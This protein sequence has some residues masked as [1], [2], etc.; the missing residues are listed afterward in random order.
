MRIA[1]VQGL[2]TLKNKAAV[3]ALV[4]AAG[5]EA[6]EFDAIQALAQTPDVHALSAYLTGL[7]SKNADLRTACKTAIAADPRRGG[8]GPGAAGQGQRGQAGAAARI[9]LHLL[10]SRA[11]PAMAADRPVPARRQGLPAGDGAEVRRRLHQ[12]RQAGEVGEPQGRRQAA[13]PDDARPALLAEQRRGRL[14]LRR[15]RV[16]DGPRR[17]AAGRQRRHHH[18]LGERQEGPRDAGRPRLEL[19]PGPRAGSSGQG[20]EQGAD[21]LRQHGG[22]VGVQRGGRRR[23]GPVRLP[24]GRRRRSSTWRTSAP[25]P[26]RTPGDA[27][28]GEQ[29]VPRPERAGLYQMPRGRRPGRP[30][31]PRPGGHRAE[32]QAART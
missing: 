7:G 16:G 10:R 11:D 32:V 28:R 17:R 3:P 19:R 22:A 18:H 4:K 1:A 24:Q 6:T 12:L 23:G 13:R 31:R 27:E 21:P 14:R 30:G 20:R 25:S 8:A 5:D 29:A 9:A 26:A 2:G 15:G